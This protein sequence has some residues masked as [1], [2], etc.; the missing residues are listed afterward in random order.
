MINVL[1]SVDFNGIR[2]SIFC[3][4][5]MRFV[6][7]TPCKRALLAQL[8]PHMSSS[9]LAIESPSLKGISGLRPHELLTIALQLRAF[10]FFFFFIP[11]ALDVLCIRTPPS[12]NAE[13]Q[14]ELK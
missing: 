12:A 2:R 13:S 11:P 10:F 7:A 1:G 14:G 5:F 4:D 3:G 6:F 9:P 8:A